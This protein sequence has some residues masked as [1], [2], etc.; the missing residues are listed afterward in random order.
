MGPSRFAGPDLAPLAVVGG[1]VTVL[2]SD[3]DRDARSRKTISRSFKWVLMVT[4]SDYFS[5][6]LLVVARVTAE[7]GSGSWCSG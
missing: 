3:R 7:S 5:L 6:W 2:V 1:L 4:V